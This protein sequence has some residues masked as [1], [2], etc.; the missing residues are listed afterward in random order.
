M[1]KMSGLEKFSGDIRIV[2][3]AVNYEYYRTILE[4]KSLI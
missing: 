3:L 4:H 2:N 1:I